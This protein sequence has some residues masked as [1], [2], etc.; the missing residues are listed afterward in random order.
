MWPNKEEGCRVSTA[1]SV[2]A[3]GKIYAQLKLKKIKYKIVKKWRPPSMGTLDIKEL[4]CKE[5]KT[6]CS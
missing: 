4:G 5:R 3:S 6:F 2:K 1:V